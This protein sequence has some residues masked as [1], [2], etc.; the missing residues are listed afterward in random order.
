VETGLAPSDRGT[1]RSRTL[2]GYADNQD[3][4]G[5]E[6]NHAVVML[7]GLDGGVMSDCD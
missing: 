7:E 3:H 2:A 6:R 4:A 1:A 5:T